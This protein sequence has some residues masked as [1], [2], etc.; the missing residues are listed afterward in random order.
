MPSHDSL[1]PQIP[2]MHTQTRQELYTIVGLLSKYGDNYNQ[3][4][5]RLEDIIPQGPYRNDPPYQI[6]PG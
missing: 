1:V 3:L 5:T 2:V 6:L 4:I